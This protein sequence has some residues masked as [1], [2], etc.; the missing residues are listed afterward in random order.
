M[1]Y[2]LVIA[3]D[4]PLVLVGLRSMLEWE[5]Y[6][7]TIA[8]AARNGAQLL[9][10]IESVSPD[11]VITDI[12]MP[13]KSGL[14]VM[15]E[16][17][18][19]YG[20]VPLFIVL[21]SH[22]EYGYVKEAIGFQAVNYLVKIELTPEMLA[23]S[24]TRAIAILQDLRRYESA[25][26]EHHAGDETF[27]DT[28]YFR[29][30][31]GLIETREQYL[32]QAR[33]LG[34]EP[35][36]GLCLAGYGEL[37]GDESRA[38]TREKLV[39]LYAGTLGLVRETVSQRLHCTVVSLDL[40]HFGIVLFVP[41]NR[42]SDPTEAV[43]DALEHA[44][45]LA[46]RYFAVTLRCSVGGAVDDPYRIDE[47]FAAARRLHSRCEPGAAIAVLDPA[48]V[49]DEPA[50][51]ISDLREELARAIQ[52]LD[53]GP[54]ST[55]LEDLQSRLAG[56]HLTHAQAMDA[57]CTVL[58]MAISLLPDGEELVS[59]I[60]S[61][62][63]DGYRSVYECRTAGECA[64][65]IGRLRE[66]LVAELADRRQDYRRRIV[67]RVQRY[68]DANVGKKL[69]LGEVA[70]VFGFSQNYLSTMFSRYAGCSFVE[71]TTAAK[72]NAAKRLL[73]E[74]GLRI[75]DIADRLGFESAFYFSKVFKKVE[76]R[77]PREYINR[78]EIP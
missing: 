41:E 52:E 50:F 66:G 26:T 6:G 57:A 42:A 47:S 37:S 16:C 10:L 25:V 64:A 49:T 63:H 27:R 34:I 39:S 67:S 28:F 71:Y 55:L 76:G 62:E 44:A 13:V 69:T 9:E 38:A 8:G 17:A 48:D 54:L 23:E 19:R 32:Q 7:I 74:G 31:N 53:V 77:S 75:Q 15:R 21:T 73:T 33:D 36:G 29:L 46:R 18:E 4:E 59:G 3:D 78:K 56:A 51:E 35:P 5:S 60:F 11:I 70:S 40:R 14:E 2:R 68:I 1:M 22:E 43:R 61:A 24:I 30:M 20:R 12:R 45:V 65:W 72:V 58:F